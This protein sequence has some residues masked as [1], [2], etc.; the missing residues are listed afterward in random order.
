MITRRRVTERPPARNGW[1]SDQPQPRLT[2]RSY[3]S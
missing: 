3:R 1:S 2:S